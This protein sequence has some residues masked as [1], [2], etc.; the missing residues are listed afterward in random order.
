MQTHKILIVSNGF[1]PNSVGGVEVYTE[2][3]AR[4]LSS[5]GFSVT[6]FARESN[7]NLKDYLVIESSHD[8]NIKVY[9]VI[10]DYKEAKSFEA[11]FVDSKI[12]EIFTKILQTQEPHVTL[13]NHLI[14]LSANLPKIS[15]ERGIPYITYLHD[16][17][18]ICHRVNLLDYQ[19]KVCPGPLKGGDCFRCLTHQEDKYRSKLLRL[20]LFVKRF[21]G[22]KV[23]QRLRYFI[24]NVPRTSI[25][26]SPSVLE[27]RYKLFREGINGSALVLV[28]SQYLKKIFEGNGFLSDQIKVLPLGVRKPAE[29]FERVKKEEHVACFGFVGNV[30]PT[31]GLHVLLAAFQEVDK[32]ISLK[33]FGRYD[34]DQAYTNKIMSIKGNNERIEFLGRFDPENRDVIYSSLDC[35]VIPSIVPESFSLV[36]REALIRKIPVIASDIGALNEIVVS[37]KN[38]LLVKPNS[39]TDLTQAINSI[40]NTELIQG[41]IAN[42]EIITVDEH[43]EKLL[44]YIRALLRTK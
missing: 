37:G 35:L 11:Q 14:A 9:K 24:K 32:N 21:F 3:L 15:F 36:A 31:K 10:N 17:W 13:F 33:I 5:R 4:G 18:T 8:N 26:N 29:T 6:V 38:G 20:G 39:V 19:N 12:D 34:I 23:R 41:K 25:P 42:T 44:E 30:L 1:P 7:R 40:L 43:V 28:P 22:Y 27:R 2:D 16:F